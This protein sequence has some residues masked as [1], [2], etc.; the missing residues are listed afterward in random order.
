LKAFFDTFSAAHGSALG[1]LAF[2]S[3]HEMT[4]LEPGR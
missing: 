3:C 2:R 4:L 1:S